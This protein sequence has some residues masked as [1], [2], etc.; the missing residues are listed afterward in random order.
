MCFSLAWLA[1]L[2]IWL[3][4]VG[5]IYAI[6]KLVI[7]FVLAQ[8]GTAGGVIAGVINIILW[9]VIAI[10][11]IYLCFDLI[12]CLAGGLSMPRLPGR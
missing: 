8:L 10:F 2:L 4:I 1:Q 6:L 3:V 9:V 7:P 5:A 11:V 12:S